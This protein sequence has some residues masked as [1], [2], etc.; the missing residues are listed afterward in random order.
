MEKGIFQIFF[1][2]SDYQSFC[3]FK[4]CSLT[5]T[6]CKLQKQGT[7]REFHQLSLKILATYFCIVFVFQSGFGVFAI[8]NMIQ[9]DETIVINVHVSGP[10]HKM[11]RQ[12]PGTVSK[13][14]HSMAPGS[15]PLLSGPSC[16]GKEARLFL[17]T[18]PGIV[19]GL[20]RSSYFFSGK[21]DIQQREGS[22]AIRANELATGYVVC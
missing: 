8:S 5:N 10:H 13:S 9:E 21:E 7:D 1:Q 17:S 4:I 14:S 18:I 12:K 16:V 19:G 22:I 3:F 15:L 11:F 2:P 20:E 6:E